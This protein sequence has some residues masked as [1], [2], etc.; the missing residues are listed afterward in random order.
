MDGESEQVYTN[1]YL[2]VLIYNGRYP[3]GKHPIMG[4]VLTIQRASFS[5]F[6]YRLRTLPVPSLSVCSLEMEVL[7]R[8]PTSRDMRLEISRRFTSVGLDPCRFDRIATRGA[9]VHRLTFSTNCG[10]LTFNCW[11]TAGQEKFGGLRDGY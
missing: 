6:A 10:P 11:D 8:L 1:I 9:E 3:F 4:D 2:P 7:V 5:S